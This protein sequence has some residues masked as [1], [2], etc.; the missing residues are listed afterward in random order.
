M[1]HPTSD[2]PA[3]AKNVAALAQE[4]FAEGANFVAGRL[5]KGTSGRTHA[6]VDPATGEEVY[7][8]ELAGTAD[9]DAAVAA[10][11]A[12]FPGWSGATPGERS[13]AMHRFAGVLDEKA[14]EFARLESLQCGK[15]LKLSREFDVPGSVD[16]AAFFAGAA[17]HLQGQSAGEYSAD[18]TSYVRREP[19][20]V[21][22]SIAP[23]NYPLQ[24]AAWKVLPAIAAGNTIVLKPA[25]LTPFTSLLFAQAATEAGLPDGVVNVI[26]GAGRDAGEHL[27]G[28]PDVAMTSFTGSTGVGKRV[29]EIA[30]ATVKRIHLELGGKAPFVVFDDAD[31]DAAVHGAVAGSLINT[32]QDCTAATRAY[33]QRPLY[34]A[35]VERTAALMETVR[36]GDPFADGTDLGPLI[37]HAQRDRVA[38]FVDR[39][40]GYARVVTGGE[41][42]GGELADGAYYRPTLIADAAQDSEAVQSEIFGPVLVV[43]PFDS[44][45]EGIRLANDTPYGL[46]AS[47][48]ST[49][50]FRA[51]RATR[52]I[53]AGCVWVNDHIPIL[54]EM[55][56]GGYKA[57]GYGKDMSAYSFDEY[58][59]IKHVMF[60][61]TAVVRKD[62]HR[63]VFGDRP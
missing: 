29:A 15:P 32:G 23:W 51:N 17:R 52:E 33:V 43:L 53:K 1:H 38:A 57:S 12:A 3:S 41:A 45:D 56:H 50:V 58:T 11:R 61:N 2:H 19:I 34:E 14:E 48:W 22:G 28:H 59:Q 60:D 5:V 4:L 16:N 6:V 20:G 55:P 42:P 25:E 18:H 37:S 36:L 7:T 47:A 62:W 26:S 44:D 9:V 63:T 54:S 13:D 35:F 40:R 8:Y 10:A 31:L 24:M 21:V 49:N 39:A 30:T 46:A 27:V